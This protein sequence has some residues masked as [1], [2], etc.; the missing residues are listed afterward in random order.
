MFGPLGQ[1]QLLTAVF[2]IE[3]GFLLPVFQDLCLGRDDVEFFLD[4]GEEGLLRAGFFFLR[5]AQLNAYSGEIVRIAITGAFLSG[6]Q[7]FFRQLCLDLFERD[8]QFGLIEQFALK[9]EFFATATKAADPGQTQGFF[10]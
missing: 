1:Y 5:Q 6:R 8:V 10:E 9:R 7:R 2:L 3:N 4:L